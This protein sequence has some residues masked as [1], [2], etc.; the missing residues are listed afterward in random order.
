MKG[1]ISVSMEDILKLVVSNTKDIDIS[2]KAF[3]DLGN[4]RKVLYW[5]YWLAH[6]IYNKLHEGGTE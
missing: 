4:G 2:N 5:K 3:Y 6:I 1:G